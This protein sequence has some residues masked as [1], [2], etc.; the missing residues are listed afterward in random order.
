MNSVAPK[1]TVPSGATRCGTDSVHL[2]TFPHCCGFVAVFPFVFLSST[3]KRE[4]G[5]MKRSRIVMFSVLL[6]L[7][8][9]LRL[10]SST[11]LPSERYA[12]GLRELSE[13]RIDN[14]RQI[15]RQ[16]R[17]GRE[18]AAWGDLLDGQRLNQ[19][20]RF[21]DALIALSGAGED[22][23]T[24]GVAWQTAAR[25]LLDLGRFSEA[26]PMLLQTLQWNPSAEEERRLLAA[27]YYDIGAMELALDQLEEVTNL[28]RDDFR[29]FYMM[30][31]ILSD[32]EQFE[33]AVPRYE[34]ALN[35]LPDR[36]DLRD[37]VIAGFCEC[38][39]R[40]R[41]YEAALR[42]AD[43]GSQRKELQLIRAQCHFSLRRYDQAVNLI[44]AVLS[45]DPDQVTALVM[46]SQLMDLNGE[47]AAA[48]EL[49]QQVLADH[50]AELEAHL[51]LADLL[52][53]SGRSEDAAAARSRADEWAAVHEQFT[54]LH[55]QLVS[56]TENAELRLQ[57]ARLAYRMQRFELA[58]TWARAAAGMAAADTEMQAEAAAL[59]TRG[60][61]P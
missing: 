14:V 2:C 1:A 41:R 28:S 29:P 18:T 16:L 27:A 50:P 25:I 23:Q 20:G 43:S 49:L 34:A 39:I 61:S 15:I 42:Q 52:A 37:E 40:L 54:A 11:V 56:D 22:E 13:G 33:D 32:Y 51:R 12:E 17:L 19:Q 7:A 10:N 53:S 58:G 47:T 21:E 24:R 5:L 3:G 59:I 30:A 36:Q 26:I 35:L 31:T 48:I 45:E 55:Q 9:A 4:P 60:Q 6:I 8:V 44:K 38:L 57:L 46:K